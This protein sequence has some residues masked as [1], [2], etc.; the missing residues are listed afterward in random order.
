MNKMWLLLFLLIILTGFNEPK[1]DYS[2]IETELNKNDFQFKVPS[3][4]P[5]SVKEIK[6]NTF[7]TVYD[8]NGYEI[9]LIGSNNELAVVIVGYGGDGVYEIS[10]H[11]FPI[12]EELIKVNRNKGIYY[13][14]NGSIRWSEGK[15][16]YDLQIFTNDQF[17]VTKEEFIKIAENFKEAG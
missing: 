14:E 8:N 3:N 5:F 16:S 11:R 13:N 12:E 7:R 9:E 6:M 17:S 10:D 4:L 2:S 15:V 1:I